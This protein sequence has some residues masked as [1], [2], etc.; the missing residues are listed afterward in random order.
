MG[1]TKLLAATLAAAC[2]AAAPAAFAEGNYAQVRAG[3]YTPDSGSLDGYASG[4]DGA[5]AVGRDLSR[6]VGVEAAVGVMK[7]DRTD[8]GVKRT[9]DVVPVTVTGKLKLPIDAVEL[10]GGGGVGAYPVK[11]ESGGASASKTA[12]GWHVVAGANLDV[13]QKVFVGG[14]IRYLWAKAAFGTG[15]AAPGDIR[16][17]GYATTVHLGL[18]F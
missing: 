6:N 10:F 1:T 3:F 4:F 7:T 15:G 9:V 8:A 12:F 2:L 13:T 17:D 5:V 16:L 14:E 11:Y 18:R